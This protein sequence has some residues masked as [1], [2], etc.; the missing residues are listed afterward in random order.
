MKISKAIIVKDIKSLSTSEKKVYRAVLQSF[1]KT[2]HYSAMDAAV[3]G[4]VKFNFYPK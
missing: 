2:S 1:P 3:Q 4:G